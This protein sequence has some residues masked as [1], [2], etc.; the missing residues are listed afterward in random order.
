LI[1]HRD[2]S[3][4]GEHK[5]VKAPGTFVK[6]IACLLGGLAAFAGPVPQNGQQNQQPVVEQKTPTFSVEAAMVVVDITVRDGVES[7]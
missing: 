7:R 3:S 6:Y 5:T 4:K 2:N 1:P